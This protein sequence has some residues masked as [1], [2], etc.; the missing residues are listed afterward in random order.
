VKAKGG[1]YHVRVKVTG[2]DCIWT[3]VSNDPFIINT[4]GDGGA[5]SGAIHYTVLGNTSPVERFGTMTIAGQ[6]FTVNQ[7]AGGCT[8]KL[9]PKNR[10]FKAAGGS[11]TVKV[12][13]NFSDCPWTAVKNGAFSFITITDGASGVGEGTVSYTVDP[14]SNIEARFGSLTIGGNLFMITQDGTH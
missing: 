1:S 11:A 5:G 3:A 8:F 6:I 14:N 10:K 9:S 4:S 7:A 2:A 13:P 12:K